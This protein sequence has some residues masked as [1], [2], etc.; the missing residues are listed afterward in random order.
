[1][2]STATSLP[3]SPDALKR[4][5]KQITKEAN[6]EAAQVKHVLK[7]VQHT[8]KS[9]E[10]AQKS[11]NKAEKQ[12]EKL[13]KKEAAAVKAV[14]K[15]THTHDNLLNDLTSSDRDVKL[16]QQQDIK[17]HAELEA[18]K[19]RADELLKAQKNHDDAREAKLRDVREAAA[20]AAD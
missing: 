7:D 13:S 17:L 1:M 18:K 8:E 16:K 2:E 11:V 10:K 15:A 19:A 14:N 12:N 3:T 9:A 5:E 20:V 4:L 6:A